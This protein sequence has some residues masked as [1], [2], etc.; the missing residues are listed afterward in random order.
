MSDFLLSLDHTYFWK[1]TSFPEITELRAKRFSDFNINAQTSIIKRIKKLPPR[2]QWSR[3]SPADKVKNAR[4]YCATRELRRIEITGVTL[5]KNDK[6]WL[7]TKITKFPDLLKMTRID[8]GFLNTERAHIIPPNPD[9]RYDLIQGEERLKTLETALSSVRTG[10]EDDP[11]ERASDWIRQEDNILKILNDFETITDG[12]SS[13]T[14][15]WE[16]FSSIHSMNKNNTEIS[17]QRNFNEESV[18]VL[19]L[20]SKLSDKTLRLAINGI[21]RWLSAWENKI[22]FEFTGYSVWFKLWPIAVESTDE[23]KP[24]EEENELDTIIQSE[25][26]ESTINVDTL[27]TPTGKLVGVFLYLCPTINNVEKPFEENKVLREM[28]DIIISSTAYSG[29]IVKHRLIESLPYFLRADPDWAK[30]HLITPLMSDNI[31]ATTFWHA[32]AR[33]TQRPNIIKIIGEQM[34]ERATDMRLD[35]HTRH[36]LIFSLII[37]CLHAFREKRDPSVKYIRVQQ[38]I[39]TLTDED[40]AYAAEAIQR[41]VHDLAPRDD[42]PTAEILFQSAVVPFL[43]Q[44]WPQERSLATSGVSKALA[45]LPATTNEVFTD[46]VDAIERF[47]VPFDCWSMHEYGLHNNEKLSMINTHEKAL[48]LLKLL[49]L[50]IGTAESSVIPYELSDALKQISDVSPKLKNNQI[51]HR[52]ET[53]ARRG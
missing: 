9:E 23:N 19:L 47:L 51:F 42:Y 11:S 44:V 34:T 36:S 27:N 6:T 20:I 22:T 15:V 43:Q 21:T 17:S 40:R 8:E 26:S 25:D 29:L 53:A 12:G 35:R 38:M 50:T 3:K 39:R 46:T 5:T 30:E 18:R 52:L 2:N 28:R 48:S 10:W 1:L 24:S 31:E 49:D 7:S 45:D 13:Y 4:L 32:V 41:F 14:R 37:E 33:R 16:E